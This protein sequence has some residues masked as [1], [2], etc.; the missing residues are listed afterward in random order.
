MNAVQIRHIRIHG[1][2][3]PLDAGRPFGIISGTFERFVDNL[4]RHGYRF[5]NFRIVIGRILIVRALGK[6]K[7]F[8]GIDFF[9]RHVHVDFYVQIAH[10]VFVE[11]LLQGC[12]DFFA[13][14]VFKVFD[15]FLLFGDNINPVYLRHAVKII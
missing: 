6:R 15:K 12:K 8:G 3:L 9:F 5:E 4:R 2:I 13:V 11:V 14:R 10:A 7:I 1:R